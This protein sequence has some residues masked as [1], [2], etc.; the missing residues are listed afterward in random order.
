MITNINSTWGRR[1]DIFIQVL[2]I[3]SLISLSI[4]TLPNLDPVAK[5]GLLY[6]EWFCIVV[7]TLEYILRIFY[8]KN[9][10]KYIFSFYGII[11]FLAIFPFYVSYGIDLRSVRIFR[12]FRL[13]RLFKLVRYNKALKHFKKAAKD[14]REEIILFLMITAILLYLSATGI[15][16]FEHEAQPDKFSSVFESLWWAISTLTTVGYGDVFPITT[17]GKIFTFCILIVGLGIVTVPAGIVASALSNTAK[18]R[19]NNEEDTD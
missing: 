1:F 7:F 6:F 13:F 3:L 19:K 17:G 9:K 11:D 10:L 5:Q 12:I 15:Y 2:I 4:E 18:E 8:A 14:A 16:F